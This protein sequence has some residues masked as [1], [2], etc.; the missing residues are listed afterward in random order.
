MYIRCSRGAAAFECWHVFLRRVSS[1]SIV[2]L[3]SPTSTLEIHKDWSDQILR[4][5]EASTPVLSAYGEAAQ[6]PARVALITAEQLIP[7]ALFR[8]T[9][10]QSRARPP[11]ILILL[12]PYRSAPCVFLGHA[13]EALSDAATYSNAV[14][15]YHCVLKMLCLGAFY[16]L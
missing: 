4:V 6:T 13:L 15:I 3:P 10:K 7:S 9:C 2:D 14:I 11:S 8:A 16:N 1:R 5:G 12:V